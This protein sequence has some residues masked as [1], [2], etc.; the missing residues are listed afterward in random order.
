MVWILIGVAF[1]ICAFE[2]WNC[3]PCAIFRLYVDLEWSTNVEVQI[4]CH[5]GFVGFL[6]VI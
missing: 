2:G 1:C 3:T 5:D 4:Q 6:K